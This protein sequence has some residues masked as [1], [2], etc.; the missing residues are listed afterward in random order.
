M[1]TRWCRVSRYGAVCIECA[2]D[3][4]AELGEFQGIERLKFQRVFI[5][6][7]RFTLQ[8]TRRDDGIAFTIRIHEDGIAV[9][10]ACKPATGVN[11]SDPRPC[12]LIPVL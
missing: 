12:I 10:F 1:N 9:K 7:A 3:C 11:M 6:G 8:L 5:P 4:F 2:N